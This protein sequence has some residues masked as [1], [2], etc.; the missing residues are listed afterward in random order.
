MDASGR[1]LQTLGDLVRIPSVPD[2][3]NAEIVDYV[4]AVRAPSDARISVVPS[5]L[6]GATGVV[7]SIGPDVPGGLILSGHLD[8]VTVEGQN[9]SSDPFQLRREG[10]RL[11]GRGTTDMKGFVACVLTTMQTASMR[12][13]KRPL[14][15]CLSADEET[16]CRSVE[17]LIAHVQ[18]HLPP[19]RGVI[20]GNVASIAYEPA[21]RDLSAVPRPDGTPY[22]TAEAVED[23]VIQEVV[24]DGREGF[25]WSSRDHL[26]VED[27]AQHRF[28]WDY[29][30]LNSLQF[31]DGD[32]VA[33]FRGCSQV[34][35][36][37]GA[38]A[39]VVW[40]LGRSNRDWPR[41]PLSIVGDPEGE[42]RG[43][44]SAR[45]LPDGR[46]LL[47]DNGG[48]C[49]V[50]PAGG[51]SRREGGLFSRVVEYALDPGAGTATFV[52]HH[53]L[54]GAFDRYAR[55]WGGMRA[56]ANGNWPIGWGYGG[57]PQETPPPRGATLTEIDP[58]TG[59]ELL[60][61]RIGHDGKLLSSQACRVGFEALAGVRR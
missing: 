2:A 53:G 49:Q 33:S 35:R 19:C 41:P 61:V 52:R 7:A 5:S 8:V 24:P 17:T 58:A 56:L 3:C 34:L 32:I 46:L 55:A 54:H 28:P 38:S 30:H 12:Q 13:Q 16:T 47:F 15:L 23:S 37:D 22:G 11:F 18:T 14:H 6:S 57:R 9:W 26:A 1:M 43:Q 29:A 51:P 39:E 27:C 48:H 20:V 4:A 44:H 50:D 10:S 40:R 45:L 25:R 21:R 36:I 42:F 59:E 31:V 60:A